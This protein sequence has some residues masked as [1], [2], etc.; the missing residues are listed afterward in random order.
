VPKAKGPARSAT[1]GTPETQAAAGAKASAQKDPNIGRTVAR[2]KLLECVG[3]GKTAKVYR[4]HHEAF[5]IDV[6]VKILTSEARKIPQ[7]IERFQTEAKVVARLDNENI[8]KIYDVGSEGDDHY[9][10]MELLDGFSILDLIEREGQVDPMDALRIARQTA[11]GLAA[12]HDKGI[13]HRDIKPQN[14]LLLED[15]TVK[16]LDFGLAADFDGAGERVGTPHY[17]A[18]ETCRDGSADLGTD[19][20]ALGIVLYHMLTGQPPYAGLSIKEILQKHIAGEPLRPEQKRQGGLQRDIGDL[21]REMTKGDPLLR[22]TAKSL[23]G[24]FDGIGGE[25]LKQKDTLK[26]RRTSRSRARVEAQKSSPLGPLLVGAVVVVG[27][28]IAIMAGGGNE[29]ADTPAKPEG[30]TPAIAQLP[31][32]AGVPSDINDTQPPAVVPGAPAHIPS[33]AEKQAEAARLEKEKAERFEK[34]KLALSRAEGWARANWHTDADTEAV[35][36][37][38]ISVYQRFKGTEPADEA[39]RRYKA[40]K[41]KELH[42]HPDRSWSDAASIAQ[43]RQQWVERKP[44]IELE[45]SKHRYASALALL[46]ERVNDADGELSA[47]LRFWADLI[48]TL[49]KFQASLV[50][51]VPALDQEQRTIEIEGV[52][53]EVRLV[54]GSDVQAR[55]GGKTKTYKWADIPAAQILQLATHALESEGTTGVFRQFAFAFAHRLEDEFWNLQLELGGAGDVAP[56]RKT[57]AALEARI[58]ARI[59]GN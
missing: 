35:I 22:P 57:M 50:R 19:V 16:V 30:E 6:A 36:D 43:V 48:E 45:L 47:E 13:I 52:P 56:F 17:M 46:P 42:P 24:L 38:Y 55:V 29:Q 4:A 3:R 53:A 7:L 25:S 18:P 41:A 21:V 54:T 15:G 34:G 39:R 49:R 9:I 11:N 26:R 20:Y 33:D 28:L 8:V 37:K 27:V 59:A 31:G 5:H 32:G 23:T 12:A 2:C 44:K 10:V 40:I 14:L 58:D 1:S 51:G